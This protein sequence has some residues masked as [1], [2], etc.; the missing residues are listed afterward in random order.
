MSIQSLQSFLFTFL[1][2][3]S[4]KDVVEV[5]FFA[6]TFYGIVQWLKKDREKNLVGYFYAYCF[7]TL[8]AYTLA[9]PSIT[10]CLFLFSP[11]IV[12]LFMFAHQE[13]LQRNLVTLKNITVAKPTA[14]DWLHLL[15][16]SCLK[17]LNNN[18]PITIL[19]EH[20]DS[21][22]QYIKT[23][24]LCDAHLT[25]GLF[26]LLLDHKVY[27]PKQMVWITSQG[28]VRGVNVTWK[29]AWHTDTHNDTQAWKDDAA[30]YST[31][32]DALIMQLD[33]QSHT[34]T[35]VIKG[36]FHELLTMEQ[37]G[38]MIKKHIH[39]EISSTKKGID[40]GIIQQKNHMEQHTS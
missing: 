40:H 36:I 14:H 3:C 6:A 11:A 24:Y 23:E 10:Y 33:P 35:I 17:A 25:D 39:Y 15:L 4:W 18:K 37:A 29:A 12:L 34:C 28:I 2:F 1:S 5:A 8:I 38:S 27:D 21:V 22:Q 19:L 16:R 7:F 30:V 20:T 26:S 13:T 31:K 32:S 9:L